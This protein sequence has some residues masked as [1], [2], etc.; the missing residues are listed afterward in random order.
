MCRHLISLSLIQ[1]LVSIS[2]AEPVEIRPLPPGWVYPVL[3]EPYEGKT[4][5]E[6]GSIKTIE[7]I[8]S[9]VP[10]SEKASPLSNERIKMMVFEYR[11]AH[12]ST[13]PM[14]ESRTDRILVVTFV[15][16]TRFEYFRSSVQSITPPKGPPIKCM[17]M[18]DANY[19]RDR[20]PMSV[21]PKGEQAGAD[22][23]AAKPADKT[24]VKDQPLPPTSKGGPR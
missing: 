8:D 1:L 20:I 9:A 6:L 13:L 14:L 7:L 23:P 11:L 10:E 5:S 18:K 12:P 16:G 3:P 19:K 17:L 15:D 22:L 4:L 24:P 2:V 21:N